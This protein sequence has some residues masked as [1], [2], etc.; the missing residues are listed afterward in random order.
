MSL[1]FLDL[2]VKEA[3]VMLLRYVHRDRWYITRNIV[4][5]KYLSNYKFHML[6]CMLVVFVITA[7]DIQNGCPILVE[8]A[9]EIVIS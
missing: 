1:K 2:L 6:I 8:M 3:L 5:A 9:H 4:C 7:I